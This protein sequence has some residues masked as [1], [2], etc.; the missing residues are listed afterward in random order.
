M[1]KLWLPRH[2]LI[3]GASAALAVVLF[4]LAVASVAE[5]S[6]SKG[7]AVFLSNGIFVYLVPIAVGVQMGL[8]RHYHNLRQTCRIGGT[9]AL[10]ASG[11]AVSSVAMIACCAH[12]IVDLLPA[13]GLVLA[14]SSFL[15]EYKDLIIAVGLIAN[16][17][18]SAYLL[19]AILRLRSRTGKR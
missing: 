2:P 16:V 12:H 17:I 5:G 1:F 19:V 8:F 18:G 9:D 14:A 11:S 13:V 4:N 10:G 7:Y 3:F 6:I 15:I